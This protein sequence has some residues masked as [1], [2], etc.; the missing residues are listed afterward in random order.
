MHSSTNAQAC[1]KTR[2]L[3]TYSQHVPGFK[4]EKQPGYV[5]LYIPP[6]AAS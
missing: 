4:T 3:L 2:Y 5:E 6:P 1:F